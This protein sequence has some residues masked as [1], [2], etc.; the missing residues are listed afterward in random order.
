VVSELR[1]LGTIQLALTAS[2]TGHLVLGTMNTINAA[3]TISRIIDSFPEEEQSIIRNMISESLRGI[4]CQQLIP[5]KDGTGMVV[6]YEV[7]LVNSSVAN[8]IRTNKITQINNVITTSKPLGMVL[9]D[10]SLEILAKSGI[11]TKEEA[12]YR[13]T[14]PTTM[15]QLLPN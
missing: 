14:N 3:Q 6:A 1:D 5:K 9:M 10:N 12:C 7:L 4:I 2:E 13:A 11:I 15:M 8:M